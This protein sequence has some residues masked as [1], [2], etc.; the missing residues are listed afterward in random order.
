MNYLDLFVI[1]SVAVVLFCLFE[2]YFTKRLKDFGV[3]LFNPV[4]FEYLMVVLFICLVLYSYDCFTLDF[5]H[6]MG[7]EGGDLPKPNVNL[8]GSSVNI[9]NPNI[10]VNTTALAKGLTNVGVGAAVAGGMSAASSI[11]KTT[12]LPPVVKFGTVVAGGAAAGV[13]V[14]AANA[15][16]SITQAKINSSIPTSGPGGSN[17]GGYSCDVGYNTSNTGNTGNNTTNT[18]TGSDNWSLD[19]CVAFSA[20][21]DDSV[22]VLLNSNFVLHIIILYL[23]FNLVILLSSRLII[24]GSLKLAFVK[25]IFGD[26]IHKLVVKAIDYISTFNNVWIWIIVVLLTISSIGSLSISYFILNNIDIIS[27]LVKPTNSSTPHEQVGTSNLVSAFTLY[28]SSNNLLQY[29]VR[30][31]SFASSISTSRFNKRKYLNSMYYSPKH[32]LSPFHSSTKYGKGG[33]KPSIFKD[34]SH[35]NA[36]IMYKVYENVYLNNMFKYNIADILE[37][38]Y[39]NNEFVIFKLY[40]IRKPRVSY[41]MNVDKL[42]KHLD[43]YPLEFIMDNLTMFHKNMGIVGCS[44]IMVWTSNCDINN[45]QVI[46]SNMHEKLLSNIVDINNKIYVDYGNSIVNFNTPMDLSN[47]LY[48]FIGVD[49]SNPQMIS[50]Y[51]DFYKNTSPS[52]GDTGSSD[53]NPSYSTKATTTRNR[54]TFY[55]K[56]KGIGYSLISGK[57]FTYPHSA[58]QV[59]NR[60]FS[61]TSKTFIGELQPVNKD[62]NLIDSLVSNHH[63]INISSILDSNKSVKDKQIDIEK[64]IFDDIHTT[65]LSKIKSSDSLK[66]DSLS[67]LKNAI[68]SASIAVNALKNSKILLKGKRHKT[69]LINTHTEILISVVISNV[70]PHGLKHKDITNQYVTSLY[71]IIGFYLV[72]E[73]I[74]TVYNDYKNWCI[75]FL[76]VSSSKYVSIDLNDPITI[77]RINTLLLNKP[78]IIDCENLEYKNYITFN[79]LVKDLHTISFTEED[80]IKYGC[81]MVELISAHTNLYDTVEHYNSYEE[82]SYRLVTIS[83]ESRSEIFDLISY[84][85]NTFP[86]IYKPVDWSIKIVNEGK[87]NIITKGGYFNT[88]LD[89]N[90]IHNKYKNQGEVKLDNNNLIK[91]INYLQGIEYKINKDVLNVITDRIAN[92]LLKKLL[93]IDFHPST[94]KMSKIKKDGDNILFK[95]ILSHNSSTFVNRQILTNAIL[96]KN[97]NSIYFPMFVDWRGRLYCKTSTFSYQG[98]DLAKSLLLFKEGVVINKKGVIKLKLY[99]G[100]LYGFIKNSSNKSILEW[101]DANYQNIINIDS[102]FWM[103]GKDPFRCLAASIELRG[104]EYNK[105]NFITHLPI[106]IDGTCNGIQH[107]SSMASDTNLGEYV[108][109]RISNDDDVPQDLYRKMADKAK[110]DIKTFLK[111][112]ENNKHDSIGLINMDRSFIKRCIMTIPYGVTKRGVKN[113]LITEHFTE[114]SKNKFK[115]DRKYIDEC[116][117]DTI[118]D[119]KDISVIAKIIH[120]VLFDY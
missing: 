91:T 4:A 28:L 3:L 27:D 7:S 56:I 105:E 62:N 1:L 31:R 58:M 55:S 9:H 117:K 29:K 14:T 19:D 109:L 106:Y 22:M 118:F 81:D 44:Y 64:Y 63:A 107:L 59:N 73:Y 93:D 25:N 47:E 108:N 30:Y 69:C 5:Y 43:R 34:Y 6:L 75:S 78:F 39:D 87:Y 80:Y 120:N 84:S 101:V 33:I 48:L 86:M 96:L 85:E 66:W 40:Y 100:R 70:I 32:H 49:R 104:Y 65:L 54:F 18:F 94:N 71:K 88:D 68:D 57:L 82:K 23:L 98:P 89:T 16:N 46:A 41:S 53:S 42:F 2:G 112:S 51:N 97:N 115:A 20:Y 92:G 17:A 10:N 77:K 8:E 11:V 99:A 38:L 83:E 36:S 114:I 110:L 61:N 79:Q 13:L 95:E 12:A 52:G 67:I 119:L 21:D 45:L 74:K 116:F 90:F 60:Y 113:Q 50:D 26:H 24:Q 37:V 103:K 15:A 102:N 111:K 76:H 35:D 72:R